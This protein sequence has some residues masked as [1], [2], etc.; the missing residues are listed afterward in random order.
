MSDP[1][2]RPAGGP[3]TVAPDPSDPGLARDRTALAWTRSSLNMAASGTLIARG[4]FTAH[5]D[6]LAVVSAL[7]MAA[8][9]VL[10]WRHGQSI[11]LQRRRTGTSRRTRTGEFA[12]LTAATVLTAIAAVLVSVAV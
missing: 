2:E 5:L 8:M 3:A 1:S 11:Y 7:A 10:T 9:A 6:A 4:A 12:L